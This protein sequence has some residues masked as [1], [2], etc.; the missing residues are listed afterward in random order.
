MILEVRG[1]S[2][3]AKD[4]FIGRDDF[5]ILTAAQKNKLRLFIRWKNYMALFSAMTVWI[6]TLERFVNQ[7][8]QPD[9]SQGEWS[10]GQVFMIF[11]VGSCLVLSLG[12][13]PSFF[14]E[15]IHCFGWVTE[16]SKLIPLSMGLSFDHCIAVLR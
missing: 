1:K 3:E 7:N 12:R 8:P 15:R 5:S 11:L 9:D 10:F 13:F 16:L 6:P 2:P 4:P 14:L